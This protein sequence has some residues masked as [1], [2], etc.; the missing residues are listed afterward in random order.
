MISDVNIKGVHRGHRR[1]AAFVTAPGIT[2][3]LDQCRVKRGAEDLPSHGGLTQPPKNA[4]RTARGVAAGAPGQHLRVTEV[5]PGFVV[6]DRTCGV[7]KQKG[8]Q[9]GDQGAWAGMEIPP[10]AIA[11]AFLFAIEQPDDA[12]SAAW[13][14]RTRPTRTEARVRNEPADLMPSTTRTHWRSS[15]RTMDFGAFYGTRCLGVRNRSKT[16]TSDMRLANLRPSAPG[17]PTPAI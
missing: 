14:I 7:D 17:A 6:G 8:R 2:V 9:G 4:V 5:P 3:I 13:F 15:P 16:Q 1:S 10:Q 11:R 12:M